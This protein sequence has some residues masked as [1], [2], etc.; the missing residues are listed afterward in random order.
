MKEKCLILGFKDA[1]LFRPNKKTKH[2]ILNED[3][4]K[5]REDK[6]FVNTPFDTISKDHVANVLLVLAGQRPIP[7]LR[8]SHAKLE[9]D[10]D[11][12]ELAKDAR[13]RI[14]RGNYYDKEGSL[15]VFEEVFSTQKT[16]KNS[17]KATMTYFLNLDEKVLMKSILISWEKIKWHLGR[18]LFSLFKKMVIDV[19]GDEALQWK[20]T[21]VFEDL[22]HSKDEKV[23]K[24]CETVGVP[25]QY[26]NILVLGKADPEFYYTG[27]TG[28]KHWHYSTICRGIEKVACLSGRIVI[29]VNEDD[30][31]KFEKGNGVATL[32]DGGLVYIEDIVDNSELVFLNTEPVY[33]GS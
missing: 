17:K 9:A 31:Q 28:F 1:K 14:E 10:K 30:L 18:D 19:L 4:Y 15:K 2:R 8:E 32:L 29:P 7:R 16:L 33:E 23:K 13:V 11:I 3:G 24:F 5:D 27:Y 6:D 25:A 12:I 22:Y 21:K 20:M 26:K